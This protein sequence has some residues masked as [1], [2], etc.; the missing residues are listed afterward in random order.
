M[1]EM[2]ITQSLLEIALRHAE[3]AGAQRITRLNIVIGQL[4]SVVDDSVQFYWDIISQGTIAAGA[5][6]SFERIPASLR[7]L[8]CGHAFPLDSQDYVC[9]ACNSQRVVVVGGDDF[10]LDS[11]EVD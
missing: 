6:L 3:E 2:P 11:I 1:H 5:E 10:R 7:C 4:S 8:D 9:A